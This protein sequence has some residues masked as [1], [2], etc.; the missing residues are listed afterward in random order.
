MN[1][2]KI[3]WAVIEALQLLLRADGFI[4]SEFDGNSH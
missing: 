1:E 3:N 2:F 4:A